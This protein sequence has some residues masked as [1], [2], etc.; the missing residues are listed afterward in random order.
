DLVDHAGDPVGHPARGGHRR[1]RVVDQPGL[2]QRVRRRLEALRQRRDVLHGL[3]AL[4]DDLAEVRGSREATTS[5]SCVAGASAVPTVSS[6]MRSPSSPCVSIRA[7]EFWRTRLAN[8]L[9]IERST[10]TL[11]PGSAGRFTRFTR[12]ICT[13]ASRTVAPSL[14]PPTS[15]KSAWI[16]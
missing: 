6:T 4:P 15:V 14:R 13:P 5:P 2:L 9:A 3:G 8:R 11:P 10:R 1:R 12:P 16:V 7:T